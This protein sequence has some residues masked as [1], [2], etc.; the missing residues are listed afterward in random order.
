[1]ICPSRTSLLL[2]IPFSGIHLHPFVYPNNRAVRNGLRTKTTRI[3]RI[4][5]NQNRVC[6]KANG[7]A[8]PVPYLCWFFIQSEGD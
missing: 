1:M 8:D 5:P 4:C 3:W 7:V 2:F 6:M